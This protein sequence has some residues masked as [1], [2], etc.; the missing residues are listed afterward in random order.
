MTAENHVTWRVTKH[1]GAGLR[2][3]NSGPDRPKA[4]SLSLSL[5]ATVYASPRHLLARRGWARG[6]TCRPERRLRVTETC[7]NTS[8]WHRSSSSAHIRRQKT[9]KP[10]ACFCPGRWR[11]SSPTR[12]WRGASTA[13]CAKPV[14]WPSVSHR[15]SYF[16][17]PRPAGGFR[18]VPRDSNR[19]R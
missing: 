6:R 16:C 17:G 12:R 9:A 7:S 15:G 19:G 4:R 11:R 10:R 13:S 18:G 1:G 14:R 5:F 8:S 2:L 3:A